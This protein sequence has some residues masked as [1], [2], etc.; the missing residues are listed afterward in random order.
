MQVRQSSDVHVSLE[1]DKCFRFQIGWLYTSTWA[2][3]YNDCTHKKLISHTHRARW[4]ANVF[5]IETHSKTTVKKENFF[6]KINK[7]KLKVTASMCGLLDSSNFF[8]VLAAT[9]V[10]LCVRF[11]LFSHPYT[12][13]ME[14]ILVTNPYKKKKIICS[15]WQTHT[16]RKNL[17]S[18]SAY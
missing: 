2:T 11:S 3:F 1:L 4:K 5:G 16:E 17:W 18:D 9:I 6:S 10:S 8:F 14:Y 12:S 15:V 7:P 13:T